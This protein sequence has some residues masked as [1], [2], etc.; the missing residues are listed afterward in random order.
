[1]AIQHIE[2][3]KWLRRDEICNLLGV[4]SRTVQRRVMSGDIERRAADD[5]QAP[6]YRIANEDYLKERYAI[7]EEEGGD[8]GATCRPL[9]GSWDALENAYARIAELERIAGKAEVFADLVEHQREELKEV[10]AKVHNW[11]LLAEKRQE[12]AIT[13]RARCHIAEGRLAMKLEDD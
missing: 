13:W 12:Q 11:S 1:M 3:S 4:T 5:N 10:R 9:D 8:K 2:L 6:E 7:L